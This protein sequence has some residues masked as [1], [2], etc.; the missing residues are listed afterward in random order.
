M[1]YSVNIQEV[2][3]HGWVVDRYKGKPVTVYGYKLI[4]TTIRKVHAFYFNHSYSKIYWQL[5]AYNFLPSS[6]IPQWRKTVLT[7]LYVI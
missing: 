3:V 2:E 6:V 1:E 5:M 7:I 4:K